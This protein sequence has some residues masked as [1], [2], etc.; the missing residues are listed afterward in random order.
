[1]ST[2]TKGRFEAKRK[3]GEWFQ[4]ERPNRSGRAAG[5]ASSCKPP[6]LTPNFFCKLDEDVVYWNSSFLSG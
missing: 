4:L 3:K 1:M 5:D 2:G 6:Y